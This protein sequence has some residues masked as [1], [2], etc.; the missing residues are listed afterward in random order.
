[1]L[2]LVKRAEVGVRVST[3]IGLGLVKRAEVGVR[4]SQES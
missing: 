2:G 1:M 3:Y 4:V